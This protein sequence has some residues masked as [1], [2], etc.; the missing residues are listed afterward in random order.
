[1]PCIL[2]KRA[3]LASEGLK[4][5]PDDRGC[6]AALVLCDLIDGRSRQMRQS[7]Q[8]LLARHPQALRTLSLTVA[9]LQNRGRYGEAHKVAQQMLRAHPDDKDVVEVVSELKYATHW[10]ML[11]LW[12]IVRWGWPA[13][14]GIWLGGLLLIGAI[15]K[16]YPQVSGSLTI[17]LIIYAIYSWVWP[18]VL[19]RWIARA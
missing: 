2:Q 17:C 12:P 4:Y 14:I 9:S 19:R 16:T 5:D 6:L 8:Q 1:M 11:P 15:G 18:P 13:A 3:R 10:S 7:L